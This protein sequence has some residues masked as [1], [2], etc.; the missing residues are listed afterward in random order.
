MCY[1]SSTVLNTVQSVTH[2]LTDFLDGIRVH[3]TATLK[4]KNPLE[5]L[6]L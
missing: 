4:E 3:F 2:L 1:L 5:K 6:D